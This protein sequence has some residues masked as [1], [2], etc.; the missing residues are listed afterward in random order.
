MTGFQRGWSK[1]SQKLKPQPQESGGQDGGGDDATMKAA[2]K[3]SLAVAQKPLS[4]EQKKAAGP[5]VHYSFGTFM[6]G[7]Y[8]A[9]V[10]YRKA[11]RYAAG[12]PF[13]AILFAA[14]DE[15]TVPAL[16]LS[17]PPTESPASEHL[18]GLL[19]HL[20]YG[21]TTEVVRRVVRGTLRAV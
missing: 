13:G 21:A 16:G 19:S 12:L 4:Q 7:V 9:A 15:I 3:L 14:A 20:V 5:V 1:A 6:G 17:K 11:A 8:G 2:E 10:E 18:Y